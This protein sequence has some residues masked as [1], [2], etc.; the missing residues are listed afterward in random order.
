MVSHLVPLLYARCYRSPATSY[1]PTRYLS[2]SL[3]A[4]APQPPEVVS[5]SSVASTGSLIDV[6]SGSVRTVPSDFL[7]QDVQT[8]T[9]ADRIEREEEATQQAKAK[10]FARDKA[11]KAKG[12]AQEADS[13]IT[14][15]LAGLSEGASSTLVVANFAVVA[16]VAG[17]LGYRAWGLYE[18]GRLTWKSIGL[19]LA[20]LGVVTVGE[21]I[22]G[23]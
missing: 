8:D 3:Q 12:K 1:S 15:Q 4:A 11:A 22:F 19:E 2:F 7:D 16:G 10:A 13:W 18:R 5:T 14:Q 20:V 6:D 23:R 17:F 21:G 9:Q